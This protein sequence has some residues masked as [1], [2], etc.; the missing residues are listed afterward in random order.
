MSR[1]ATVLALS[2]LFLPAVASAVELPGEVVEAPAA[3]PSEDHEAAW[4]DYL[5]AQRAQ[6]LADLQFYA[7]SGRFP[8]H[9]EPGWHHQFLDSNDVPCAVA[10][11]IWTSGH[12]G[13]VRQTAR[14]HN[15]VV[16]SEIDDGPI[17][18]WV[19]TSGLTMEE[20][21]IIQE[22]G[23]SGNRFVREP[24]VV[25][26]PPQVDSRVADLDAQEVLRI[27]THLGAVQT[28]LTVDTESSIAKA[29]DR[30]GDRVNTP[31]PGPLA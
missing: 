19:H 3:N 23:W 31:P 15:D 25:A 6:R 7:A 2:V 29:L 14:T 12:E 4:E 28:L 18:D 27:R 10:S 26:D 21:A 9:D 17:V 5:R 8:Q 13:L 20:I 30:L 16:V 1:L 22:P 11:L 24:I